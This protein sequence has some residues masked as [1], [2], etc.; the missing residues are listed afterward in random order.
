[1]DL[2]N[3]DRVLLIGIGGIGMSALARFFNLQGKVVCGYDR[4]RS[5]L[6]KQL[7][8]E[9][10]EINYKDSIYAFSFDEELLE[11]EDALI[12]YTPA[13]PESNKIYTY[14]KNAGALMYKRSEVLAEITTDHKVIAVA[15]T[16]GKTTVSA[17]IAH[18]LSENTDNTWSFLGG[19]ST[20]TDTNFYSPINASTITP[21]SLIVVEAD[22]YD[23]SFLNLDPFIAVITAIEADHLDIYGDE[24]EL[25]RSFNE[26]ANQLKADGVLVKH[27]GLDVKCI[28]QVIEYSSSQPADISARNITVKDGVFHFDL[29]VRSQQF[30]GFTCAMPGRHNV[31][32]AVA[33]ITV[34]MQLGIGLESVKQSLAAFKG[35]K[36][37]FEPVFRSEAITFIDDYAHHPTE[38]KAAI[39]AVRELHPQKHVTGI[40][41]PHLF[42]RTR[43]FAEQFAENLSEL[44]ELILLEIYPARETPIEGVSSELIFNKVTCAKKLLSKEELLEEVAE[45]SDGIL[46]SLGA[47]DIDKI[48]PRIEK[49][50]IEKKKNKLLV[51]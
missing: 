30:E 48:V 6:T 43:D 46:I 27:S 33:A 39:D 18:I 15:G 45:I 1:M 41:Q 10:I 49:I 23:R 17:M 4:N 16:H 38:I 51:E 47:G 20:N 29:Q 36:R 13:I 25:Q 40:F 5:P 11:K 32:N 28:R 8:S 24:Q 42:S 31:E 26:F 44:D 34:C 7:E 19:I 35:V 50:L 9:G 37:R 3:I 2:Q 12:I 21:G 14:L 22:E